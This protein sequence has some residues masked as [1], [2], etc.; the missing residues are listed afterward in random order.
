MP[1]GKCLFNDAWLENKNH[2]S[3]FQK[4]DKNPYSANCIACAKKSDIGNMGECACQESQELKKDA[5]ELGRLIS[6]KE[7]EIKVN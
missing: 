3:W 6:K 2:K 4:V 7:S 1:G 5:E